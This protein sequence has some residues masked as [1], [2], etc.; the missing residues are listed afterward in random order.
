MRRARRNVLGPLHQGR[1]NLVGHDTGALMTIR[2]VV[3]RVRRVGHDTGALMTIRWVIV[4]GGRP[5][6]SKDGG[7]SRG[8]SSRGVTMALVRE[9][10]MN[11]VAG[12]KDC[13]GRWR[14]MIE[15]R[16]GEDVM[17]LCGGLVGKY[18]GLETV[19]CGSGGVRNGDDVAS[20]VV[21]RSF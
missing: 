21:V 6:G 8:L 18:A 5:V 15:G 17:E 2:W 1:D 4:R 20:D 7:V 19:G 3:V 11:V 9:W 12:M 13:D 14:T 16:C 10:V